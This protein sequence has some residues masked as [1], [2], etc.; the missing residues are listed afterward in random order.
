MHEARICAIKYSLDESIFP[1]DSTLIAARIE[2]CASARVAPKRDRRVIRV[3]RRQERQLEFPPKTQ[4]AVAAR[5][6]PLVQD[7]VDQTVGI[8]PIN[9]FTKPQNLLQRFREMVTSSNRA[10]RLSAVDRLRRPIT[11]GE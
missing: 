5:R 11:L 8:N 9:L 7:D 6:Q 2:Y 3:T 1:Y 4:N 10:D